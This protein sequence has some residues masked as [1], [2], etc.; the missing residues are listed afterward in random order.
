[1]SEASGT[2]E[3][4]FVD[5]GVAMRSAGLV[6]SLQAEGRQVF[7]LDAE[8]DGLAQMAAH[9]SDLGGLQAIHLVSHG[10]AGRVWLGGRAVGT[11]DLAAQSAQ[12]SAVGHSLAQGGDL[13]L[14]GCNIA[15]GGDGLNFINELARLTGAHV[16]ASDDATGPQALGGDA[17]LEASTGPI[18]AEAL[19]LQAL[20][21]LLAPAVGNLDAS[22]DFT[23]GGAPITVDN[24]ITVSGGGTYTEGFVRFAVSSPNAGDQFT[25]SSSGTPDAAG[26]IS[27][28]GSDVYLGN[29]SG[30]DRIGSVDP[31]E[32][33]RNGQPLKVLFSSPLPNAG[34]EEGEANWTVRDQQYGDSANEINFDGY[35]I[36]L[37][38]NSDS[39]STYTGGTGT[40][41]IQGNDGTS[42]NGSVADGQ[43]INGT[44]A[45][46][47][48]SG[49]DILAGDQDPPGSFQQNGYGSIHGPYATSSVIS[50]EAGDSISLEFKAVG[51]GDDYEVFGLLRRVDGSGNFISNAIDANNIVLFAERGADTGGFRTV[52]KTGLPAGNYRFEF[53]GGTYDGSGGLAVGS[54]LYVDNIRL[55]SDTA[56]GDDVVTTIARQIQYQ[57]TGTD[58][59]PSRTV[60][61]T[62][63]NQNGETGSATTTLNIEQANNSPSFSGPATLAAIAED[64]TPPG[65]SVSS[66][67][68]ALFSDPDASYTPADTLE[69]VA[70]TGNAGNDATQGAWQYS[71]DG[72]SSWH[73]VGTVSTAQALLLPANALLRFAPVADYYGT[74]GS[75]TVHAVDSTFAGDF[76]SGATRETF[77]TT[78]DAGDSPVSAS[79]VALGT[80]VTPVN[81]APR[82]TST[83]VSTSRTDTPAPDTYAQTTGIV[84]ATDV[85]GDAVTFGISGGTASGGIVTRTLDYGTLTI[86][87]STGAYVFTPDEEAINALQSGTVT[88]TFTI[89]A[90][91]GAATSTQ[92]FTFEA[93]GANDLPVGVD[94]TGLAL[95]A[96]GTGNE[97]GGTQATGNVLDN[98]TDPDAGATFSVTGIA[99]GPRT[100]NPGQSLAGQYGTL[101]LQ[102]DGSYVYDVDENN[103]DVE[104]LADGDV[105][106]DSFTY[107]VEDNAGGSSTATLY[108]VIG[109]ANEAPIARADKVVAVEDGANPRGN[110]LANDFDLDAPDSLVVVDAGNRAGKY[111]TLVLK[112]DGSYTYQLDNSLARVNELVD[113]SPQ[114]SDTFTYTVRDPSGLTATG[115][116]TVKVQGHNDAPVSTAEPLGTVEAIVGQGVY[117]ALPTNEVVDPDGP[118]SELRYAVT[119]AN[120]DPVPAWLNI[121]PVSGHLYG[122][123]DNGDEGVLALAIIVTDRDGAS[124]RLD[125]VTL[126]VL[127]PNDDP[128]FT[129]PA[130]V[131]VPDSGTAVMTVQAT[132][133]DDHPVTYS[134]TGG[135]DA[136][137]FRIDATTGELRFTRQPDFQDPQDADRDNVYE[138]IIEASDG[139]G[140][141]IRRLHKI[142]LKDADGGDRDGDGI[143]DDEESSVPG[144]LPD[145]GTGDGNG[146]GVPDTQQP[147]VAS[148]PLTDTEGRPAGHA[149]LVAGDDGTVTG[150]EVRPTGGDLP[151]GVPATSE[152]WGFEA[153]LPDSGGTRAFEVFLPGDQSFTGLWAKG[154]DGEWVKLPVTAERVGDRWKVSF[155]V[156]DGGALDADG[157]ANG[158]I[159]SVTLLSSG[160]DGL[161]VHRFLND[162]AGL[163]FH[164]AAVTERDGLVTSGEAIG[165]D[166][167]GIAFVAPT[168]GETVPVWRFFHEASGDHFYTATPAERDALL[169]GG[170]GY[171]FEGESFDVLPVQEEGTVPVHRYF[172]LSSADHVYTV[173]P[174]DHMELVGSG[175]AYE[176]VLGYV[177]A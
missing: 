53:V 65:A 130:T 56:V 40:V 59:P 94:D 177:F 155:E 135:G 10:D 153:T 102:A 26:A 97:D 98:D 1:M 45:L 131:E 12:W 61:V 100:A 146:D 46:Y 175:Y 74:P 113:D 88:Q 76:S 133:A 107:T 14:Y 83:A 93:T 5:G 90:T 16:A 79:G 104:G 91:D 96:G 71:T 95:E 134:I 77:D 127:N 173:D 58:S 47:L 52:T 42:F 129:S 48:Q 51:S 39:N 152:A 11:Q 147:G 139:Q 166:Y 157:L 73:A 115:K 30:R 92:T 126:N 123:P 172:S 110:V 62:T 80:S 8:Q 162:D 17:V 70:I 148:R 21:A 106:E 3:V 141:A 43:G 121:D 28:D 171:E 44:K 140:G 20:D 161:A 75:L 119:L 125:W 163:Q 9:L 86:N 158:R 2:R 165:W 22:I 105:L 111:G 81:D 68:G 32:N 144:V 85:E 167:D 170:F 37:A 4:V 109:G 122:M 120:G 57:N 114:L 36:N 103:A 154:A 84:T 101:V 49:G 132:D 54:N 72:G 176:G 60:T 118:A 87:A 64:S 151:D 34:F 159:D 38:N 143:T 169:E 24:N 99:S 174:A 66:L 19:G 137:R 7:V 69:G 168:D 82:F 164:T 142:E 31:V 145:T 6:Q 149:T 117:L 108:I 13:L 116:L 78:S 41:N 33:G 156:A 112:P 25:L 160:R 29:G 128:V 150:F 67:F 124:T 55:I 27:V 23:E 18:E 35:T 15:D 63:A 50:V 138:V 89:T 136:A